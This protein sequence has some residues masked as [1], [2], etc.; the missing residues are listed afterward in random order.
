MLRTRFVNCWLLFLLLFVGALLIGAP[1]VSYAED[2]PLANGEPT[3]PEEALWLLESVCIEDYGLSRDA[4]KET[5]DWL[6]WFQSLIDLL[7][8]LEIIG[9][10]GST[11]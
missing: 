3:D 7:Y 9:G 11:S 6:D 1:S 10:D 2:D 4:P 5:K 8:R